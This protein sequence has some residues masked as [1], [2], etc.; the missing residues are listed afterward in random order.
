MNAKIKN[1]SIAIILSLLLLSACSTQT[2]QPITVT[3]TLDTITIANP[4]SAY[5][6][7]QGFKLEIRTAQDNNQYGVCMFD[8]DT[9]CE[10]W[11]YY[12]DECKPG[13][14]DIAPAPT[15]APAGIANPASAYCA[16]QGGASEIRTEEDGSQS[17]VCTFPDGSECEEWAFFGG[18]CAP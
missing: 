1:I 17:A 4:A 12:R 10:E 13:D 14:M 15:A 16:E 11:A 8:D 6:E 7:E 9:E 5:C 2:P 18:E 3:A